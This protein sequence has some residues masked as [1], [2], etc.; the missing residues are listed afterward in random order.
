MDIIKR[1]VSLDRKLVKV[2][3]NMRSI[4]NPPPTFSFFL[5]TI[6]WLGVEE[7]V[8]RRKTVKRVK[9]K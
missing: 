1:S 2:L 4:E 5:A 7:F 8:K 9:K 6:A 3:D